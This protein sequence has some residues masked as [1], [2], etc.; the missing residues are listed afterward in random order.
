MV[1][2]SRLKMSKKTRGQNDRDIVIFPCPNMDKDKG[3]FPLSVQ[4]Q[5]R[6]LYIDMSVPVCPSRDKG[7]RA[8]PL[9]P[10]EQTH[11][12]IICDEKRGETKWN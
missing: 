12:A 7:F 1:L 5:T 3:V 9:V 6:G 10:G 4:G 11:G 2:F 8:L